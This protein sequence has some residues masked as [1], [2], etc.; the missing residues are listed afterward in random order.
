[1][2]KQ[3]V[4]LAFAAALLSGCAAQSTTVEAPIGISKD[5]NG[6]QGTP[7]ACVEVVLEGQA[8]A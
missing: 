2:T 8:Q 5:I 3:T 7:C 6:L 4:F 1:M